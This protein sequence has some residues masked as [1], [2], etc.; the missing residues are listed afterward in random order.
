MS[1]ILFTTLES[2]VDPN[3]IKKKKKKEKMEEKVYGFL[4]NLICIVNGKF[5]LL[6][7]EYSYL[8]VNVL[9]SSPKISDLIQNSFF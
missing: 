1:L 8:A 7:P 3:N 6:Q 9:T 2:S 5:S 4:D